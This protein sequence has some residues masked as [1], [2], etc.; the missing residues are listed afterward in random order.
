MPAI[1][2]PFP[3]LTV[4]RISELTRRPVSAV[5]SLLAEHPEIQPTAL[6]DYRPVYDREAFLRLLSLIE[7]AEAHEQEEA[8][9]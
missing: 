8:Q 3:L 6:A 9:S 5:E 1:K 2:T 4:K 7:Q